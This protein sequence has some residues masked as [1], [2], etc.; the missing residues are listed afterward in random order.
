MIDAKSVETIFN[1][2][3]KGGE[4]KPKFIKLVA[5]LPSLKP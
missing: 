5:N 1:A 4:N 3:I 2:I